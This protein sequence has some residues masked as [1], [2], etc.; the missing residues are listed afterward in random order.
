MIWDEILISTVSVLTIISLLYGLK[1]AVPVFSLKRK[2]SYGNRNYRE[3]KVIKFLINIYGTGRRILSLFIFIVLTLVFYLLSR[4]IIFSLF[5]GLCLE[6]Y[7]LD[8]LNGF[9]EKRKELLHNQL[10]EFISNMTVLLKAGK[11]V[12]SI[13]KDSANW[14][15]DPLRIHLLEV[16]NEL[17]LNSTLDEALDRFSEK[18]RSR[19]ANLLVSSLKI[20]NKIGGDLISIL[21]NIADSM[22]HNLKLKSQVKTMSLQSRYSGNI[23]S[24][25]PIIVLILL[26]I[27]M[28][29]TVVDFFS[30]GPGVILLFI[31]GVLEIA[32]VIVMKKII[33]IGK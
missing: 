22:R 33:N 9:E 3:S 7:I 15:K 8:L 21:D 28:N 31:G 27:F 23:I 14:F 25:F 17:E 2:I 13:F 26:Y 32:G 16:A 18:C 30:T 29:K 19:E 10:I 12:R 6:I 20:N 11:T 24:I 5:V 1:K 4:N